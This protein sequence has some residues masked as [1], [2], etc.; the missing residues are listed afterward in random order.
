QRMRQADADPRLCHVQ[1]TAWLLGGAAPPT[2]PD[3][4]KTGASTYAYHVDR[5]TGLRV[6]PGCT[7]NPTEKPETA[8]W[9]AM[10]EAWLDAGLRER[11][12]PPAWAPGCETIY[13]PGESIKRL[14]LNDGETLSQ[15][16]GGDVPKAR[17]TVRGTRGRFT[18]S[19]MAARWRKSR[20]PAG[21]RGISIAGQVRHHGS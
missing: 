15:A 7:R 11:A 8:R 20:R 2:F 9:P 3:R 18:G 19:S 6:T 21:S 5:V 10:L 16:H 13:Q 12:L 4:L 17:L 1:R 14:G